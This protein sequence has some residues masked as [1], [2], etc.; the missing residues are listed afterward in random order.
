[1]HVVR[2]AVGPD[3]FISADANRSYTPMQAVSV[4]NQLDKWRLDAI[5]QP[6]KA[7]DVRG[8]AF[9]R[10]HIRVPLMADEGVRDSADA[11]APYRSREPW[12]W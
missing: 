3:I 9:V 1:M 5:E 11:L 6:V 10:Q 7:D 4:I 2:E 8:M 12:T